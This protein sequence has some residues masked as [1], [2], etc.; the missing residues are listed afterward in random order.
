MAGSF[1][2]RVF[3]GLD[4]GRVWRSTAFESWWDRRREQDQPL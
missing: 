4:T 1:L 2:G 3:A